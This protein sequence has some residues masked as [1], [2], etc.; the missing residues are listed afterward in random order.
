MLECL[1]RVE[2]VLHPVLKTHVDELEKVLELLKRR[3]AR[4]KHVN[5]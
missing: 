1:V 4:N 2:P 3:R 5:I